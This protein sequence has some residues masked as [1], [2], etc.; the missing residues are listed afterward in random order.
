ME[1]SFI[2]LGVRKEIAD[3]LRE[4]GIHEPTPVQLQAIPVV[5]ANRDVIAQ[6]QTGTGKTLPSAFR[7][8]KLS[9]RKRMKC[10]RSFSLPRGSWRSRLQPS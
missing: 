2:N 9:I 3:A 10:R 8:W 5:I 7:Y 6:A 1:Q 4:S